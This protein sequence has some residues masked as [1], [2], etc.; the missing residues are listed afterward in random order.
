MELFF[1]DGTDPGDLVGTT[2]D[3]FNWDWA[4]VTGSFDQIVTEPGAVWNTDHLYTTGE[5]TL[6]AI[7][8]P[9]TLILLATATLL[10]LPPGTRAKRRIAALPSNTGCTNLVLH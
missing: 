6:S 2:F 8:E 3:L 4:V 10:L 1:A 9:S 7:P 5:V